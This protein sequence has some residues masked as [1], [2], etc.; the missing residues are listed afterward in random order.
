VFLFWGRFLTPVLGTGAVRMGVLL[1]AAWRLRAC[2]RN[3]EGRP[4]RT[5]FLEKNNRNNA[6]KLKIWGSKSD[7]KMGVKK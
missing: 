6:K 7:P 3:A 5:V 2:Q 4:C 1:V